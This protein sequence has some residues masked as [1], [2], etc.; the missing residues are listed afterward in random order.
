MLVFYFICFVLIQLVM[1][2]QSIDLSMHTFVV[3]KKLWKVGKIDHQVTY[4]Q[5]RFPNCNNLGWYYTIPIEIKMIMG[6]MS[7]WQQPE[8]LKYQQAGKTHTPG[9]T[10]VMAP[11]IIL[12]KDSVK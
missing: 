4:S 6:N 5:N 3:H 8:V 1:M 2:I 10:K 7:K 12:N 9:E 11:K